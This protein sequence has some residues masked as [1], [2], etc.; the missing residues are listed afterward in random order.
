MPA[1]LTGMFI[2]TGTDGLKIYGSVLYLQEVVISV[3]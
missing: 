3:T 2:F 1:N